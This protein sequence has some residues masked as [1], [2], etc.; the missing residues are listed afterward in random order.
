MMTY[1]RLNSG[2]AFELR[3]LGNYSK[4]SNIPYMIERDAYALAKKK[5]LQTWRPDNPHTLFG[6]GI[7][8]ILRDVINRMLAATGSR[9]RY[10]LYL[11]VAVNTPVD[12]HYGV[13]TFVGLRDFD[14]NHEFIVTFDLSLNRSKIIGKADFVLGESDVNEIEAAAMTQGT[15]KENAQVVNAAELLWM[16]WSNFNQLLKGP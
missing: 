6:R 3:C 2:Q 13:D 11:Y 1:Q 7:L 15:V 16:Y 12:Q 10:G 9:R 8:R 4:L 14:L 5:Q